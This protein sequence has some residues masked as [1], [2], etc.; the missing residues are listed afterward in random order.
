MNKIK[1]HVLLVIF[2]TS[3]FSATGLVMGQDLTMPISEYESALSEIDQILVRS[4]KI[5]DLKKQVIIKSKAANLYWDHDP[6]MARRVFI[7]LWNTI[8]DALDEE[9]FSK[10]DRED[11]RIDLLEKLF[12]KDHKLASR[13]MNDLRKLEKKEESLANR[14]RGTTE[15]A[16]RFGMLSY[17]A[18]E[19]D[20]RLASQI[21]QIGLAENTTPMLPAILTRIRE[22]DPLLANSIVAGIL[23]GTQEISP[24]FGL[25]SLSLIADYLFPLRPSPTLSIEALESDEELRDQFMKSGH[26]LLSRSLAES[27]EVLIKDHKYDVG[28]LSYRKMQQALLSSVLAAMA[29]RYSPQHLVELNLISGSLL[30]MVPGQMVALISM[31]TNVVRSHIGALNEKDVTFADITSA[32]VREDFTK[33]KT[34]IGDLKEEPEKKV[35]FDIVHSAEATSL[36]KQEEG[37]QALSS[38]GKIENAGQAFIILPKILKYAHKK[39]N[40]SLELITFQ[41]MKRVSNRMGKG[42]RARVAF[43]VVTEM[44]P[45]MKDYSET[46][47]LEA[48]YSINSLSPEDKNKKDNE[49]LAVD[50]Y[51]NDAERFLN[52][53]F[54]QSAF[55]AF[56]ELDM[57]AAMR[58]SDRFKDSSLQMMSRL[59]SVERIIRKGPPPAE[60]K[61]RSPNSEQKSDR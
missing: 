28:I 17:R 52:S 27:D 3:G 4:D 16:R 42:M 51:W 29:Q 24:T 20:I 58:I 18:A 21:L 61:R 26:N 14:L 31:Q 56:G 47:L 38:A 23:D 32:L 37:E 34:L 40:E 30:S 1:I 7:K 8:N 53:S 59:A 10:F 39:Q 15:N 6:D 43:S 9:G 25:T 60:K 49:L 57:N 46:L 41:E 13:L 45:L 44:A 36:L 19:D 22:K 54:M 50:I 55:A 5:F 2:I 12:P 11:A 35:W 33:A 48:V